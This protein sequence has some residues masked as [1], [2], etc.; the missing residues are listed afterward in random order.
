M[1]DCIKAIILISLILSEFMYIMCMLQGYTN[2]IV[3]CKT[4][5]I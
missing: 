5:L 2:D 1:N 4:S 3:N